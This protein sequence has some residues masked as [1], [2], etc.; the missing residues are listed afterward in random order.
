MAGLLQVTWDIMDEA[1]AIRQHYIQYT[2]DTND[3]YL[4]KN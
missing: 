2:Y 3:P 1:V 4:Q